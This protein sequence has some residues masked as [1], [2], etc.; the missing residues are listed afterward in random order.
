MGWQGLI[1]L[2]NVQK[3]QPF[4]ETSGSQNPTTTV[5]EPGIQN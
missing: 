2:Q 5:F 1:L 4:V 3:K